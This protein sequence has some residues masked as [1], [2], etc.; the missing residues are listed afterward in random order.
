MG[1]IYIDWRNTQYIAFHRVKS[2]EDLANGEHKIEVFLTHLA[3]DEKAY[4][5]TTPVYCYALSL[6]SLV[7]LHDKNDA[8]LKQNMVSLNL[9]R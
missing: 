4:Y 5:G 8:N 6:V 3:V 9:S 7:I 1:R 2:C